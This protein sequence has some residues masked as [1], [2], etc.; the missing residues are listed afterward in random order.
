VFGPAAVF[1][2]SDGR[3]YTPEDMPK[4]R[5]FAL[6][7]H[8]GVTRRVIVQA[9]CHG[10]DNRALVDALRA[11]P[12]TSRGIAA[13]ADDITDA[14]LGALHEAGVRGARFNFMARIQKAPETAQIEALIRRFAPLGWH[15]VLHFDSEQL[16]GLKPWIEQLD[17]PVLIDHCGRLNADD[18]AGP[19]FDG[20]CALLERPN[21]WTKLSS[22]ERGSLAGAPYADML[23]ILRTI[24]EIAPDRV[25]WGTDWP[26]PVL[27]KPMPDDGAL[28][29]YAWRMLPDAA[30]RQAALVDNPARL[31]G[32]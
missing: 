30:R 23:P 10:T 3:A 19:L 17:M 8:L 13:L 7:E 16:P 1:P 21:I 9:S 32:F 18:Y 31:Y 6:H 12:D 26:H 27:G 14:E 28:V 22:A 25:I 29:D 4:E 24:V 2:Y 20:F 5:L 15:V 11:R